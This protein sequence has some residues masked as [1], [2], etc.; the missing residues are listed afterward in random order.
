[1]EALKKFPPAL[2]AAAQI[3]EQYN[4]GETVPDSVI[5]E[6]LD[7]EPESDKPIMP[8]EMRKRQFNLL[9]QSEKMKAEL[10]ENH[11]MLLVR[12]KASS[13]MLIVQPKDQTRLSMI[14]LQN[15]LRKITRKTARRLSYVNRNALDAQ[16]KQENSEALA[17]LKQVTKGNTVALGFSHKLVEK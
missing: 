7:I 13:G 12:V 17:K 8:S 9:Q 1:M 10:L 2:N 6:L 4:Y 11:S 5:L 16:Q 3:A 14:D 15:G